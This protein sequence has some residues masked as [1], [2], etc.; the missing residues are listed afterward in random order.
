MSETIGVAGAVIVCFLIFLVFAFYQNY[1][2]QK[3]RKLRIRRSFGTVPDREYDLTEYESISHYFRQKGEMDH[4]IDDIT[5]NDL[6]MDSIFMLMN[7]T[8][9]TVGE[10]SLYNL[11]R[12]PEFSKEK[13]K[14]REELIQYFQTHEKE[15]EKFLELCAEIGKTGQYSIF[16][17][18]YNLADLEVER[19]WKHYLNILL[20]LGSVGLIFVQP[21]VGILGLITMIS[22]SMGTYYGAKKKIE[23][24]VTSCSCLLNMLK[25]SSKLSKLVIPELES[26]FSILRETRKKF[27]NFKKKAAFFVAGGAV[28]GGLETIIIEYINYIFHFDLI[29][30]PGIVKELKQHI[31]DF[32]Q[33][34][35]T[36]GLLESM[37]AIAS[38]RAMMQEY[39][40]PVLENSKTGYLEMEAGYHP[41][42]TDPVK[43]SIKVKKGVLLTG[44]N[45][46]GKSTFLKTVA[47]NAILAQ[48]IHT[49]MADRYESS[50]FR[51]YSS[52]ALRDDLVGQESYYIV[53]IKSLKRILDALGGE[54]PVLCFVDE[55]LRGTNTVER[56]A[57]SSQ[58]LKS[59]ARQ[60]VVC[61]A[62][63]HDVELTHLLEQEYD[64]YHFQEEVKDNDIL[65]NYLLYPGRATS[66][67]AIKLLSIMGYDQA[68][69]SRAEESA[70]RFLQ[71]GE[72]QMGENKAERVK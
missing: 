59:V 49:C 35:D 57:A 1:K 67:N 21:Q 72:W 10:S 53:E 70:Q 5:W 42:I 41:M 45:A 61:F 56:I 2:N 37:A 65:F 30:F 58:I 38:F 9:S 25:F 47:I 62:A 36:I 48:T 18:I 14:E 8:W 40:V 68:I 6:D 29:Q 17:Y 26:Y 28:S 63:T 19:P 12:R 71:T 55:V 7:H 46:S 32:E 22:V 24:Y 44:S 33:M 50:F 66:R 43:N 64:N 51:V 54:V 11:L 16:D 60:D 52:M 15:R 34:T 4:V 31:S 69:I 13:L 39:A 23:P 3:L 20:V 27:G